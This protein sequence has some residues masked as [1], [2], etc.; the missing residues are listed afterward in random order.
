MKHIQQDVTSVLQWLWGLL[1]LSLCVFIGSHVC[2]CVCSC[3]SVLRCSWVF[4]PLPVWMRWGSSKENNKG[5]RWLIGA[6]LCVTHVCIPWGAFNTAHTLEGMKVVQHQHKHNMSVSAALL[7]RLN[8]DLWGL[9]WEISEW[10]SLK[11]ML[12]CTC[13]KLFLK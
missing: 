13:Y 12:T 3:V 4:L 7:F 1:S 11:E 2:V 5:K 9:S 10:K 8:L 6:S